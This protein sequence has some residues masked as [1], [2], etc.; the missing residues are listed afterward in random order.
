MGDDR[1]NR[2]MDRLREGVDMYQYGRE[3]YN[4]GGNK[5]QMNEGLENMMYAICSLIESGMDIAQTAEEKEIIRK[6]IKKLQSL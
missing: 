4:A 5:A 6:H 2:S 1:M 3:R